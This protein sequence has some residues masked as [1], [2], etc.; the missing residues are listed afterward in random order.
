[1]T[2]GENKRKIPTTL[3]VTPSATEELSNDWIKSRTTLPFLW[4][5]EANTF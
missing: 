5:T 4:T 2:I 1:M 3:Q